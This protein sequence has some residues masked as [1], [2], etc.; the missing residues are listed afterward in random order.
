MKQILVFFSMFL[1]VISGNAQTAAEL[2]E[3]ARTFMRQGDYANAILV[4]NRAV[5]LE[6]KNIEMAKDLGLNYYFSKDLNK[7]LETYKPILEREDA[8]DQ[9][10]Q[11]AGDIY[12]AMDDTKECEKV[13]KKGLKKFPESG[14]LYNVYGELLWAQKDYSAIKQWEKGIETNPGFSK[15]YYNACKYYYFT[16]DKVW[17]ILYGEIFLNIEPYST[18]SA[19]IKNLLL[20]GY[21]KLFADADLEKNGA[22]QSP[23]V[24]AFLQSMNKQS[25]LASAGINA[26]S[27]TMIR[28][29]FI[30]DWYNDTGN[31]FPYKLF[32]LQRQ[33]LQEGM[34]DAY[35][36]WIFMAAQ[37]LPAYQNWITV[38][39]AA[40][41]EL[42]R[43]QKG[44]IFKIPAGQYYH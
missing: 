2:H 7:A 5:K 41:S 17:S 39:A 37:N 29:R 4:L 27:L 1:L 30:L 40:Y 43:F 31:K 35:N 9:C 18:S 44:R 36:Q 42:N 6:P 15:N 33:L 28:A 10:F 19:E 13:Y 14:A 21:K 3:T 22:G 34:F 25:A 38:N 11:I 23:F 20:E 32:E 16:T 26:E 8:D 24:Q 12:L